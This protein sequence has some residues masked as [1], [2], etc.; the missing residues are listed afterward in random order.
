MPCSQM[1]K[2][3]ISP[4]RPSP[5]SRPA[6]LPALNAR[7]RNNSIRNIGCCTRVSMKQKAMSRAA[8]PA[9]AAITQGLVQP[10]MCPP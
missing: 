1:I 9:M 7:I 3:N 5:D 8:P 4:P 6:R 10:M 2:M